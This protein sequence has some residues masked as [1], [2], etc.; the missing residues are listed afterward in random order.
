M[1][2]SIGKNRLLFI[3]SDQGLSRRDDATGLPLNTEVEF[4]VRDPIT[5]NWDTGA[6]TKRSRVQVALLNVVVPMSFYAVGGLTNG[7]RYSLDGGATWLT[8]TLPSKN[9]TGTTLAAA[10][11]TLIAGVTF[12]YDSETLRVSADPAAIDFLIDGPGSSASRVIGV[13]DEAFQANAAV[14]AFPFP[15]DIAGPRYIVFDTDL[16]TDN[17][18]TA[19]ATKGMLAAVPVTG[20]PGELLLY[21]PNPPQYVETNVD[22][23]NTLRVRLTDENH[24]LLDLQGIKWSAQLSFR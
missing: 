9:Y 10:L 22:Q 23:V 3:S 21:A 2:N 5:S 14:T 4:T 20:K 11:E 6:A 15:V 7:L 12:T 24:N 18:D 1:S 13:H 17:S 8:A 19:D 16:P